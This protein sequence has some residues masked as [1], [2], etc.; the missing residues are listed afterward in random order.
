MNKSGEF[1]KEDFEACFSELYKDG[2]GTID[3]DEMAVF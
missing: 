3:K 1:S 2:L